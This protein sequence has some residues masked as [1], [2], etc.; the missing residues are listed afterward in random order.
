VPEQLLSILKLCL[1][2]LLYLFFLRVIRAVWVEVGGP[3]RQRAAPVGAV[4]AGRG[5]PPAPVAVTTAAPGAPRSSRSDRGRRSSARA[6][7]KGRSAAPATTSNAPPAE[8]GPPS[9]VVLA[10]PE[11]AGRVWS[12]GDE[13]VVGRAAGC[14]LTVDDAYVS[15]MHARLFARDGQVFVEDLG[16]TNGTY[17]NREKVAGTLVVERGD[18]VQVGSIV[19]ELV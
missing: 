19:M 1:L 15:Q 3:R 17:L 6:A 7:A 12:I 14:A 13:L 10:P 18:Q 2:V 11:Q 5:G 16:S 9:L 4:A 8:V